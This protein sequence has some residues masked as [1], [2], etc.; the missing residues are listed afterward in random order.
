MSRI[1]CRG[2]FSQV[3]I[4]TNK[5]IQQKEQHAVGRQQGRQMEKRELKVLNLRDEDVQ[6]R[7]QSIEEDSVKLVYRHSTEGRRIVERQRYTV[8]REIKSITLT[9]CPAGQSE[10]TSTCQRGWPHQGLKKK[11][12]VDLFTS[13]L[14]HF[15]VRLQEVLSQER[16]EDIV[17]KQLFTSPR[18]SENAMIRRSLIVEDSRKT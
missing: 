17:K 7:G 1:E 12:K 13:F 2:R 9:G 8:K 6:D 3:S 18:E 5:D 15:V 10:L 11:K 16:V 14:L 4:E